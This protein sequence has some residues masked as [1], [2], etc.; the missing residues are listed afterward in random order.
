MCTAIPGQVLEILGGDGRVA[1]V[2]LLGAQR[3]IDIS[4]LKD[5]PVAAGD[6]VMIHVG[7][8]VQK[9]NEAEA[10]QV[11]HGDADAIG[12]EARALGRHG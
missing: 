7:V 9:V 3:K 1:L 5:Q 11:L 6:W 8:A 12:A 2:D 10:R 4:F